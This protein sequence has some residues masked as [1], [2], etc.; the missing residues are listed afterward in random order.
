MFL[1]GKIV[2]VV[3][4]IFLVALQ[5]AGTLTPSRSKRVVICLSNFELILGKFLRSLFLFQ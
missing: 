3:G 2:V 1:K 4:R 5:H